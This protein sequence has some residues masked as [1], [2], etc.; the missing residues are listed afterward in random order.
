MKRVN[1]KKRERVFKNI[2]IKRETYK[3]R[4]TQKQEIKL[5][6]QTENLC[7]LSIYVK[8][9]KRTYICLK[10][11]KTHVHMYKQSHQQPSA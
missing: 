11:C 1:E 2:N 8:N 5:Y 10:K 7:R 3:Q 9:V 4:N 6:T